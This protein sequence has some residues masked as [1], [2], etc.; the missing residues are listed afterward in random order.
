[1]TS[2]TPIALPQEIDKT[3]LSVM[4]ETALPIRDI[5]KKLEQI[6]LSADAKAILDKLVQT[7]VTV[8]S[9]VIQ[10]GRSIVSFVFDLLKIAPTMLFGGL[11][12]LVVTSCI[13]AVP[14]LGTVLG[15]A[16][17]PILSAFG[18]GL[19]GLSD[20]L[21]GRVAKQIDAFVAKYQPLVA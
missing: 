10:I 3:E 19:G 2:N 9:A 18:I 20:L 12:A 1:M 4:N 21:S 5:R 15:S 7:T 11:L 14:L 17:A 8:G 13:A 6:A 16:L